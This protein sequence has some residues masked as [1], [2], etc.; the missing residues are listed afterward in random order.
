M[1]SSENAMLFFTRRHILT[2]EGRIL[3]SLNKDLDLESDLIL[4]FFLFRQ[5][6]VYDYF[7]KTLRS[8]RWRAK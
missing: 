2:N 3:L 7:I 4:T 1:K 8:I 5:E 6:L